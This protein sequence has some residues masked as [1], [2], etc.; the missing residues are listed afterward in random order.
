MNGIHRRTFLGS[1]ACLIAKGAPG[2][3][4]IGAYTL[5]ELRA[6]Y[7]RDLFH[8]FLP[9][10]DQF[11]VDHQYGGFLCDTDFDGTRV[12]DFKSALYE[13]RGIWVYSYL[14]LNF[15]RDSR[16]L[17]IARRSF[18]LLRRSDP[19]NEKLWCTKLNRDGT[20]A[21]PAGDVLAP[22]L[23]VVEGLAAFAL[24]SKTQEPLDRAKRLF[25]KCIA[26]YD[27]PDYNPKLSQTFLGPDA[28]PV[29][30]AR[31]IGMWMLLLRC[32]A[33]LRAA[34]S[35]PGLGAVADRCVEAVVHHHFNAKIQLNNEILPHDLSSPAG[36]FEQ[37]VYTG[38]TFEITW[39]L[40]EEAIARGDTGLFNLVAER[41]RR[42]AEVAWDGVY[43]GFFHNL[44]NVDEN[45]WLLNKVLWVQEEVLIDA[46]AILQRTGVEWSRELFSRT[47]DYV[48][49]KYPL[50][51][52][53]S[54]LWM[55]A[56][57]RQATFASFARMPKRIENYHYPRQ[58]IMNLLRLQRM[59]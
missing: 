21:G 39:M 56:A 49:S 5:T 46:L 15:G 11:V 53:G 45:R 13:G 25:H 20:P 59:T 48:R 8:G 50:A 9:F 30:G 55:Y 44:Q 28:P 1:L 34:E 29:P 7:Q 4:K 22:D 37:L 54:P 24:A 27:R 32:A 58:L 47:N 3:G 26:A 41:F 23:A 52:H 33:Q 19:G 18:E 10:M 16:Y 14:Y 12:D 57:D 40:L 38:H 31:N 2:T 36:E 51:A 6:L 43:G 35:D 42:H 17:E